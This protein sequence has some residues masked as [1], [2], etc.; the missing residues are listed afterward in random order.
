MRIS[1]NAVFALALTAGLALFADASF[2]QTAG[3]NNAAQAGSSLLGTLQSAV[4]GNL[5]LVVGLALAI[6]GI[7]TWV[8]KQETA[9]GIM[10]I[11]GGV[12]LT[13]APGVFNTVADFT[14]G[15]VT[16]AS[17]SGNLGTVNRVAN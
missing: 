17:G 14:K 10:L 1:R 5:G 13:V 9:A 11:I 2:A 8:V 6:L 15:L 16:S 4:T 12:L 3:N 7:W